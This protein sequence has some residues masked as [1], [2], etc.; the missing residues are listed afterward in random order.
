VECADAADIVCC[1]NFARDEGLTPAVRC[2]GHSAAGFGT[3]DS[4]IVIDLSRMK[5]VAIDPDKRVARVDGGCT[6][7]DFDRAAHAFG[8]ATPGGIISTTGVSGLTLGGGFGH[9]TRR[10]GL[11]CDNVLAAD[12][13]TA[14]ARVLRASADEN[15]DLFWAI[16]G[17]G[18]NF[19]VV[20]S[21]EFRLHPVATVYA[22]PV[23]YSLDQSPDVMRFFDSFM[24][25]APR[26]LSAFFAYL[27]VP[28][29][30]PFPNKLGMKTMC[31]IVYV[32]SGDSAQGEQVTRPL[33]EFGPCVFSAGGI[34]PYPAV[35]T[36]FDGLLPRGEHHYWKADFVAGLDDRIIAE[37][38]RFGPQVPTTHSA[39]HIYPL[40][41]AVHDVA[42]DDTAFAWRN[43]RFSHIVA[44]VS[45]D[46]GPMPQYR[47][48]VR[49]YWSALHPHSAGGAYVN[50]LMDEGEERIAT[51]YRG[52]HARLAAIKSK[53][54]PANLFRLNQNIRP[55]SLQPGT[56]SSESK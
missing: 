37:H 7:G 28:P 53:Y 14:D 18:G 52:N 44:A 10:F 43:V 50:F 16:R 27:I 56:F 51:S 6:W 17:G 49:S 54:D 21:F 48:W 12:I 9:L 4:G 39:M 45:P 19:G 23:L 5:G 40:D 34:V 38:L 29:G 3:C 13:V 46:P 30:P 24:A 33:R 22:G 55:A 36:M 25:G 8:L 31:G 15:S 1:V 11:A 47:D 32:W 41:G 20:T 2:G 35:Q 42:P 26:E